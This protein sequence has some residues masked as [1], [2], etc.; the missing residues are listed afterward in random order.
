MKR[1]IGLSDTIFCI[2]T[3]AMLIFLVPLVA[4][5]FFNASESL[6]CISI[7]L[8][9]IEIEFLFLG[10]IPIWKLIILLMRNTTDGQIRSSY[11]LV[12]LPFFLIGEGV[13]IWSASNFCQEIA[14]VF[15]DYIIGMFT[16]YHQGK[17]PGWTTYKMTTDRAE[18]TAEMIL[19]CFFAGL[20]GFLLEF[21]I[22]MITVAFAF[23]IRTDFR[24]I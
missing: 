5:I 1:N 7:F 10:F 2:S 13:T 24:K 3:I 22:L 4:S 20:W 11:F 17:V 18:F 6:L 8:I 12:A 16:H 23:I 19:R 14:T 9:L 21:G 15:Y